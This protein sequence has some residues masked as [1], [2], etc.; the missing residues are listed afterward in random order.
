MEKK[1]KHYKMG[2]FVLGSL[3]ILTL[4]IFLLGARS[5]FESRVI[6]E[7]YF[8][9]SVHGL[10]VGSAVKYR[11]VAIGN[12]KEISF[13]QDKYKLDINHPDYAK[14][15]Y[16]LIQMSIRDTFNFNVSDGSK[17]LEKMIHDGLRVKITS[18]GLTGTA[19]LEINYFDIE[20]NPV[21]N[22][23]WKPESIYIPS[24]QSTFTKIGAS[25]D[26]LIQKIDKADIDKFIINL[27]KLIVTSEK[28]LN[29]A[30]IED[31]SKTTI[32]LLSEMRQ[33]NKSLNS[34][35]SDPSMKALPA[36]IDTTFA[37]MNKS[38]TK[39]NQILTNNQSEI[40]ST[41]ENLRMVSQDLREVSNNAKKYPSMLLFGDAPN[42]PTLG[43]K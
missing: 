40:S 18:Q 42:A 34:F 17:K 3:F 5:L 41:V 24:T 25:L 21:M 6:V 27:D 43:K 1:S 11:G 39:L 38:M 4:F 37:S 36:K 19:Y 23:S 9:E 28:S 35:F 26:E 12:V 13:V 8:D 30:K 14:G 16:V 33:T 22:V 7:T 20:S 32:T 10:D 31:L 2:I 29:D 15:R